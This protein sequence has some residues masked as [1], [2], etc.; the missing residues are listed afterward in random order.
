MPRRGRII[1]IDNAKAMH[2]VGRR[3]HTDPR[4]TWILANAEDVATAVTG[5]VDAVLCNAA[6]WKTDTTTTF[7][8]IKRIL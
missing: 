1:S 6:I 7:A 5:P 3:T 4:I 2:A 8:A